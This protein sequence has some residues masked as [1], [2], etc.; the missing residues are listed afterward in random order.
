MTQLTMSSAATEPDWS[1]QDRKYIQ[2]ALAATTHELA[3]AAGSE[4][5]EQRAFY[6][7]AGAA[8]FVRDNT[9]YAITRGLRAIA[10]AK[11]HTAAQCTEHAQWLQTEDGR[12]VYG[13]T[14]AQRTRFGALAAEARQQRDY[15]LD[16]IARVSGCPLESLP[17]DIP[18][19]HD[20]AKRARA[21]AVTLIDPALELG[22]FDSKSPQTRAG[23]ARMF[24]D[25]FRS[26]SR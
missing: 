5:F 6:A 21:R 23:I 24:P 1:T 15:F 2:M 13:D 18:A 11:D 8:E 4:S 25:A 3:S 22:R 12:R 7:R 17:I 16:L 20:A 26:E 19:L 14:R 9:L 10:G